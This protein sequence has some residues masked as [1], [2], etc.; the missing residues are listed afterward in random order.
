ME[1]TG[2]FTCLKDI[3]DLIYNTSLQINFFQKCL[4]MKRRLQLKFLSDSLCKCG[5][6]NGNP[7]QH[8]SLKSRGQRNLV[9]C[10]PWGL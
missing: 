3:R 9:G 7:L 6:G 5:E 2:D 8:S 10:S 4:K 1:K